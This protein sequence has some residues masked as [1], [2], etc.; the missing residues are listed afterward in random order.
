MA[1]TL[2][3]KALTVRAY[4][5]GFGDCFLLTFHYERMKR[6]V[7]IDFGSVGSSR[8]HPTGLIRIAKDIQEQTEG[9]LHAVV[10]THRHRDHISGF[11]TNRKGQGPGDIIAACRPDVVIQPWTE[12]PRARRNSVG[13]ISRS[14]K[15]AFVS[16]LQEMNGFSEAMLS[17]LERQKPVLGG[18][19]LRQLSFLGEDNITNKAAV[20]NLIR[21]GKKHVYAHFGSKSGLEKILPGVKTLVLGP[22]TLRQSREI[23]KQRPEDQAEFWHFQT[24]GMRFVVGELSK[25]SQGKHLFPKANR[26]SP[27]PEMKW[28]LDSMHNL[29]GDQV[30]EIVRSLDTVLNNTSLILF[31]DTGSQKLLFPGDAQLENWRY[32]LS[33]PRIVKLLSQVDVYKVGHHGSLNATPKSLWNCFA[34]R[35]KGKGR[36]RLQTIISTE[37]YRHGSSLNNTEVPRRTLVNELRAESDY[38]TT[39]NVR[40]LALC[41]KLEFKL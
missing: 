3:P 33:K 9:K 30:L 26:V 2:R 20:Q 29:W 5:V 28:W 41:Q 4:Q 7:L 38:F 24:S 36:G 23:S 8:M 12:D 34:K 14:D 32:A 13:P 1:T 22:P 10:A 39:E 19:L 27:P 18:R 35:S 16:S 40:G 31:F 15:K 17:V 37:P 21:M 11:A 6:H 25:T